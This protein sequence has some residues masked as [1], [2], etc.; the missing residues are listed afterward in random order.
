LLA[1]VARL[2]HAQVPET[3]LRAGFGGRH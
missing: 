1:E 2:R 3:A